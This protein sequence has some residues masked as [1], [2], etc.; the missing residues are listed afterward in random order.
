M[1]KVKEVRELKENRIREYNDE[2]L[3]SSLG[4]LTS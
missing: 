2:R 3:H 1:H 4:D